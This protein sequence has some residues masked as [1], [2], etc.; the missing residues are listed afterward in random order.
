MGTINHEWLEFGNKLEHDI[1]N[2]RH[3]V[4]M[5]LAFRQSLRKDGVHCQDFVRVPENLR[6]KGFSFGLWYHFVGA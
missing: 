6:H 2:V 5:L 1:R 3:D 4:M